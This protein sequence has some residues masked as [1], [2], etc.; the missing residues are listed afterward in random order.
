V[1][2]AGGRE[3]EVW[4]NDD[5]RFQGLFTAKGALAPGDKRRWEVLLAPLGGLAMT[6]VPQE[7]SA[8][9]DGPTELDQDGEPQPVADAEEDENPLA[10][11]GEELPDDEDTP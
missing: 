10:L 7:A 11:A 4:N 5:E 1:Q 9:S 6:D 8:S 2:R 3:N